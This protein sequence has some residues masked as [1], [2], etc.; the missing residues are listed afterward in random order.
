MDQ[1]QNSSDSGLEGIIAKRVPR[2]VVDPSKSAL[3]MTHEQ[4]TVADAT[5]LQFRSKYRS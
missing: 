3:F 1:G 4:S 2:S 5:D